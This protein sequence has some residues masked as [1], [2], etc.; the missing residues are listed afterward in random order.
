[1]DIWGV[2]DTVFASARREMFCRMTRWE[3]ADEIRLGWGAT[4]RDGG[5]FVFFL[6]FSVE[7]IFFSQWKI[8][9]FLSGRY[10]SLDQQRTKSVAVI[11]PSCS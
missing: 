2:F 5:L 1:M 4:A 10:A 7:D 8:S 6:L 3:Q 11:S 9:P